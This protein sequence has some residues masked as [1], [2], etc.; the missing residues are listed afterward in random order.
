MYYYKNNAVIQSDLK[1]D[2]P[3][4]TAADWDK[5]NAPTIADIRREA[6]PSV[7]EQLDMIYWDK[8]NGTNLWQTKIAE[9]KAKYPKK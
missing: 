6:Y 1:L 4:A 9:I 5:Q 2:L 3:E 7:E 8:V